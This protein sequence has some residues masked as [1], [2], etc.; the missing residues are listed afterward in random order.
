L[1]EYF[2]PLKVLLPFPNL[3]SI[4]LIGPLFDEWAG[5]IGIRDVRERWNDDWCVYSGELVIDGGLKIPLLFGF[6]LS[7]GSASDQVVFRYEVVTNRTSLLHMAVQESASLGMVPEEV[8]TTTE[9]LQAKTY[10]KS[11]APPVKVRITILGAVGKLRLP[12]SAIPA[13]EVEVD[14]AVVGLQPLAG[15]ERVELPFGGILVLDT[16]TGVSFDLDDGVLTSIPPFLFGQSGIG[17]SVDDFKVDFS[18]KTGIPELLARPGHDETWQGI[19]IKRGRLYGLDTL[20]KERLDGLLPTVVQV[21]DFLYGTDGLTGTIAALYAPDPAG[22]ALQCEK[23]EIV[24]ERDRF[25]RGTIDVRCYTTKVFTSEYVDVGPSNGI[26][27]LA[28]TLRQGSVNGDLGFDIAVRSPADDETGLV[29][30]GPAGVPILLGSTATLLASLGLSSG[31]LTATENWVAGLIGLVAAGSTWGFV[32]D[33]HEIT[34]T[35][36][37]G[38]YYTQ[39]VAL[40]TGGEGI[41]RFVEFEVD[42]RAKLDFNVLFLATERPV[43]VEVRRFGIRLAVHRPIETIK[44]IELLFDAGNGISFDLA[45]QSL[46]GGVLNVKKLSAG[47]WDQGNW[48]GIDLSFMAKITGV[49]FEDLD[50]RI[51]T[52]D[53]GS[54]PHITFPG[55]ALTLYLPWFIYARGRLKIEGS[56]FSGSV[57]GFVSR[58]RIQG[59]EDDPAS[60]FL[61]MDVGFFRH[62]F[63]DGNDAWAVSGLFGNRTGIPI[64]GGN[65]IYALFAL[66]GDDVGLKLDGRD[67]DLAESYEDW[68]FQPPRANQIHVDK[69]E[70]KPDGGVSFGA[71]LVVGSQGD[72]GRKWNFKGGLVYLPGKLLLPISVGL[73][74]QPKGLENATP[75]AISAF[76]VIDLDWD[77]VMVSARVAW[78]KPAADGKLI[79]I[80]IPGELYAEVDPDPQGHF[81]VG[82]HSPKEKMAR[83][84]FLGVFDLFAYLMLDTETL[85]PPASPP[86]NGFAMLLGVIGEWDEDVGAGRIRVFFECAVEGRAA[87]GDSPTIMAGL[88]RLYGA[89][90]L[91]LYGIAFSVSVDV[92]VDYIAPDPYHLVFEITVEIGF[93]WPIPDWSAT[94][95]IEHGDDDETPPPLGAT[96][97]G[98]TFHERDSRRSLD[99]AQDTM[100]EDVPIDPMFTMSFAYPMRNEQADLGSFRVWDVVTG[101]ESTDVGVRYHATNDIDYKVTLEELNLWVGDP[102]AGGMKVTTSPPIPAAFM[103]TSGGAPDGVDL[104]TTLQLF[105]YTGVLETRYTGLAGEYFEFASSSWNPCGPTTGVTPV[106]YSFA[107]FAVGPIPPG[108]EMQASDE[109][110]VAVTVLPPPANAE[111]VRRFAG[112]TEVTATIVQVALPDF[113]MRCARLPATNG[114]T[115]PSAS[116]PIGAGSLELRWERSTRADLTFLVP[117]TTGVVRARFYDGD[118]LVLELAS[119]TI[120]GSAGGGAYVKAQY[121]CDALATRAVIHAWEQ[122][123]RQSG[124]LYLYLV[125]TCLTYEADVTAVQDGQAS[126]DAWQTFWSELTASG[127]ATSPVLLLEPDTEYTIQVKV[128]WTCVQDADVNGTDDVRFRFRTSAHPPQRFFRDRDFAPG[129][130]AWDI[131]TRPAAN[132]PAFYYQRQIKTTFC[133]PRLGMV[134]EKFGKRLLLRLVDDRGVDLFE[135]VEYL[136]QHATELPGYQQEFVDVVSEFPCAPGALDSHFQWGYAEFETPLQPDRW[137]EAT[138]V[139]VNVVGGVPDLDVDWTQIEP[140]YRWKFRTSRWGRLEDHALAY[141]LRDEICEGPPD[142]AGIEDPATVGGFDDQML[143]RSLCDR[144]RLGPRMP[145]RE[146]EAVRIWRADDPAAGTYSLVGIFLDGPESLVRPEMTLAVTDGSG[147]PITHTLLHGITG[148]RTLL[149]FGTPGAYGAAA[150]GE[151]RIDLADGVETA[152]ITIPVGARPDFFDPEEAP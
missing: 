102:D 26:L 3:A 122:A 152:R 34:L 134:Y 142:L 93:P 111:S 33:I 12:E 90:G 58:H 73:L 7:L 17:L 132:E 106:C 144:L 8:D 23:I 2:V 11:D 55:I 72:G 60:W 80:T 16:E 131:Q 83:A 127:G 27:N 35:A 149:L 137:Y 77:W 49:S 78:K 143:E 40:P 150:V 9:T 5:K 38:R 70:P 10:L 89:A 25:V 14:G 140:V 95:T 101:N 6:E 104:R 125:E 37:R 133:D 146:P 148:A 139:P 135:L 54:A 48:Y 138:F 46:L 128:R 67:P 82:E 56:S 45:N 51:Y 69:W 36:L 79:D 94:W 52:H 53:D 121:R 100:V 117:A 1:G 32:V 30:V 109:P 22:R 113:N 13:E 130:D 29:R 61:E 24:I 151:V 108:A 119:G 59:P 20:M 91:R 124:P 28:F 99:L 85:T 4:P 62:E 105:N 87:F 107:A 129:V 115:L 76:A 43:T 110:S 118:A 86:V 74:D 41:V 120:V 68:Y 75:A 145:A 114:G 65:A 18:E 147:E 57:R 103:P 112:L 63:P 141:R 81:Y 31:D 84:R 126:A 98:L 47:R 96:V 50:V 42:G 44:P 71:G 64:G 66:L 123:P 136:L 15:A 92:E 21:S 97:L 39:T 88:L 116:S 19:F